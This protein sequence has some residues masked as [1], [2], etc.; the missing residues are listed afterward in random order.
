MFFPEIS[1]PESIHLFLAE[2]VQAFQAAL[3]EALTGIYLHGSLAMGCFNPSSSDVD[4]LVVV[5]APLSLPQ[6]NE[7]GQ[8]LLRLSELSP[9]NGL[10]MS[11]VI[12]D[13]LRRFRHPCPYELHFSD[14]NKAAYAD[15]S[16]DLSGEKVDPDLAAHYT[17]T[18]WRGVCLYGVPV[19][20]V[21]PEIPAEAYLDSI[22]QDADWSYARIKAGPD[23][24]EGGVPA[25]SVLNA[26]R[27]LAYIQQHL[28][29]SKLEGGRW[30]LDHLPE[31]Y[32]PVIQAALDTYLSRGVFYNV[33]LHLLK[34]FSAYAIELIHRASA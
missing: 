11:I 25:Y 12:L 18:R 17:I 3:G 13:S 32:Q 8:L 28:V 2:F 26:C 34:Q 9:A 4:I 33:D 19:A 16:I 31:A 27:V 29:T 22:V 10:E 15:G 6:K 14:G 30:G 20:Q 7:L 1:A 5:G 21:F 24:G 23:R